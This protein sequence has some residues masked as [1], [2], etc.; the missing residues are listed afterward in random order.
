[1]KSNNHLT[2]SYPTIYECEEIKGALDKIDPKVQPSDDDYIL[3]QPINAD[4]EFRDQQIIEVLGRE[5]VFTNKI[6]ESILKQR[7]QFSDLNN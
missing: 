1:M 3:I 4:K 5:F 2:L 7:E 6:P